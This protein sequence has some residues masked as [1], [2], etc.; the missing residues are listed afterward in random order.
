MFE[1]NKKISID[2]KYKGNKSRFINHSKRP[3]LIA[4]KIYSNGD[5]FIVFQ[6]L[7]DI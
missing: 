1:I 2:A 7:K 3:N 4:K 5:V 6:A